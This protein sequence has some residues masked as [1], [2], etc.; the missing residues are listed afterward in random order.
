MNLVTY[1]SC[2]GHFIASSFYEGYVGIVFIER[3]KLLIDVLLVAGRAEG[4]SPYRTWLTD[5]DD[6]KRYPTVELYF[7]QHEDN[8]VTQYHER[9]KRATERL[10]NS[11]EDKGWKTK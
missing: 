5:V 2:E 4:F 6:Q 8:D 10:R 9:M 1:S 11:L 3:H 7:P